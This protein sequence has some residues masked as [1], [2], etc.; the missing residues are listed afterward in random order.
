MQRITSRG[1]PARAITF[2]ISIMF[3]LSGMSGL[4][5][6]VVWVRKFGLI[7]G[8]TAYAVGTVLTAFF[9]GLAL[10]SWLAGGLLRR[11]RQHPLRLY[12]MLEVLIALYALAIP[13]LLQSL[14]AIYK[15]LYPA[16]GDSFYL[17]SIA[18]FLGSTLVILLPSCLMGATLPLVTEAL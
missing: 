3:L 13:L 12:A 5:Y 14:N 6:Q 16:I 8:V 9:G 4:I 11:T 18:R 17:L 7:F 1:G 15:D 2:A 10:G